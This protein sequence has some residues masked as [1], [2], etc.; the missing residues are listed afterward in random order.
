MKPRTVLALLIASILPLVACLPTE[1]VD[2]SDVDPSDVEDL[3]DVPDDGTPGESAP[4]QLASYVGVPS[5][6]VYNPRLGTLHDYCTK[7]PDEFPNPIGKNAN[8]RGPCA[9]HDMCLGARISSQTCNNRLW[10]N[11]VSNCQYTYGVFNPA[12]KA[13]INTAHVYWVAVT[14]NTHL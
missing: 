10:S 9:R 5:N 4:A 13:C 11:M 3:S 12:R 6:Y 1:D 7:S 2:P 14:I 8:F